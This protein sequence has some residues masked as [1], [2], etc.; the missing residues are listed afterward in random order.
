MPQLA[1]YQSGTD[2]TEVLV[3]LHGVTDNAATLADFTS[4]FNDIYHVIAVDTLGHGLSPRFNSEELLAPFDAAV[5]SLE[6]TLNH[7][8]NKKFFLAGHSM[9]G[10]IAA[11]YA[12]RN[13]AKLKG[14]ILEDPA[15]FCQEE[16]LT[17]EKN[18]QKEVQQM[19]TEVKINPAQSIC[20]K[21]SN[22]G[23]WP[24]NEIAAWAQA[25]LQ[26]DENF[27]NNYEV[28]SSQDWHTIAKSLKVPTLV[29]TGDAPD[30][31]LGLSGCEILNREIKNNNIKT[32][33]INNAGHCVR[34]DQSKLFYKVVSEFLGNIR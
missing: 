5:A 12:L 1:T 10:A 18:S 19:I 17:F 32:T 22:Y 14:L 29:V 15:W 34:R 28:S 33:L 11:S 8:L 7:L 13:P 3:L 27:L 31:I 2:N 9:G 23:H 26:V 6:L 21:L 30:T 16:K 4:Y 20:E 25:K 24:S